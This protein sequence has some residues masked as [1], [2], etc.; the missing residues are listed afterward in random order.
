MENMLYVTYYGYCTFIQKQKKKEEIIKFL[1]N[2]FLERY[3][4]IL[5]LL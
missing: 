5:D 3:I 2:A 4:K 1:W